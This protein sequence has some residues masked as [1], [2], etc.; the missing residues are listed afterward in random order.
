[1]QTHQLKIQARY[2]DAV[3]LGKKTFEIRK[4]DR[5]FQVGDTVELICV[6]PVHHGQKMH[7][8]RTIGFVCDYEQKE[9]YVVF[10]LLPLA[11]R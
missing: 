4:N 11:G 8:F 5:D 1:M 7:L 9:G 2:W 3:A 10:S 6:D